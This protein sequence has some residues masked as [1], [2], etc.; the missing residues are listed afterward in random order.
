MVRGVD[1]AT[2][3]GGSRN[4]RGG[5]QPEARRAARR[6]RHSVRRR[7]GR[8]HAGDRHAVHRGVGDRGERHRDAPRLS[9]RDPRARR[10]ARR[11][12]RLSAE[13]LVDRDLHA[14]RRPRRAGRH[15]PRSIES[16]PR[17]L[18]AGRHPDRRPRRLQRAEPEARRIRAEPTRRRVA[19][20]KVPALSDRRR[21]AHGA[22]GERS[23][24]LGP[25][26]VPLPELP[27]SRHRVVALPSPARAGGS[28]H[29][30][31]LQ[32]E[33]RL[34]RGEHARAESRLQLRGHDRAVR[35]L[36]RGETRADRARHVSQHHGKHG[37]GARLHRGGAEGGPAA[38]PRE[39]SDH[40]RE[41]H[42]AR[43]LGVEAVRRLYVP[44]RGRDR[45]HRGGARSRVRGRD[46]DHDDERARHEPEGGDHGPGTRRRAATHH[47]RHPACRAV[48]RHAD[49]DRAGR[50]HDR[51]VRSPR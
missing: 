44:G 47:H 49:E 50:S 27:L 9:G 14:R 19:Q 43:A 2:A 13:L 34:R 16:Q 35:R 33:P 6:G 23:G 39:L 30:G 32:E 12:E 1:R 38:L 40:A 5:D 31:P 25:R 46:R 24:A 11:C 45:R 22:R 18:E 29:Q 28:V 4:V 42:P 10:N 20:G 15:E 41:R 37:D 48:D 7:F 17:R 21:E 36:L 51:H 8:R 26:S 3:R